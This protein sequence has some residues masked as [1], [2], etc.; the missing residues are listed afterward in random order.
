MVFKPMTRKWYLCSILLFACDTTDVGELCDLDHD[1][2]AF[3]ANPILGETPEVEI[4]RVHRDSGCETLKCL[5][6]GGLHPYCTRPCAFGRAGKA[7]TTT[8]DCGG[9]KYCF[10]G[11]CIDDDCPKGFWCRAALTDDTLSENLYCQRKE[12]CDSN[13]DCEDLGRLACRD[14]G[15]F[16]ACCRTPDGDCSIPQASDDANACTFHRLV[17]EPWENLV[18]DQCAVTVEDIGDCPPES[19]ICHPPESRNDWEAGTA[20]RH[21]VCIQKDIDGY[22]SVQQL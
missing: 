13:F 11:S 10:A 19:I 3:A 20:A 18:C 16:D 21:G 5:T 15:C 14:L 22:L 4:N 17:C 2:I 1:T 12:A 7:C 6:H 9:E 8:A